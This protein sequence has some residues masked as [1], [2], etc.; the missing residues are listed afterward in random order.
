VTI[1]IE[2]S[3]FVRGDP[4]AFEAL[5]GQTRAALGTFLRRMLRSEHD[6]E[7]VLQETYLRVFESRAGFDPRY[8]M[9][10]WMYTIALNI[11]RDRARRKGTVALAAEP[12]V[13]ADGRLERSELVERVRDLVQALP[14][15]QRA[16]FTLYRYEGLGYDE[17]ARVLGITVGAVKAQMHH[18]LKKVRAGLETLGYPA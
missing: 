10:T 2:P 7:D 8:S 12:S 15:G 14:E 17:V 16:V 6:A 5:V 4:V 3:A 18:A 9:K 13:P 11:L 1:A